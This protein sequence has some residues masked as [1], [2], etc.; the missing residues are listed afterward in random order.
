MKGKG[1][2][3]ALIVPAVFVVSAVMLYS[4]FRSPRKDV[5][6]FVATDSAQ[7]T[8]ILDSPSWSNVFVAPSGW[9]IATTTPYVLLTRSHHMPVS[10]DTELYAY[11]TFM[12]VERVP[13]HGEYQ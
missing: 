3:L 2:L 12:L 7:P 8:S 11:D 1:Y 13:T 4:Y 9:V 10:T 5:E 6:S